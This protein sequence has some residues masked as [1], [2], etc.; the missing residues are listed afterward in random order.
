M[1]IST[2]IVCSVRYVNGWRATGDHHDNWLSTA[3]VIEQA[4]NL[5]THGG[6]GGWNVS[7]DFLDLAFL[8]FHLLVTR[9]EKS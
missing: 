9:E 2:F 3:S 6:P 4:A 8:P 7:L 5:S 1:M